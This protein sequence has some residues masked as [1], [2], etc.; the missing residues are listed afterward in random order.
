LDK[1][2]KTWFQGSYLGYQPANLS[3]LET[4]PSPALHNH[5]I[6]LDFSREKRFYTSR[7]HNSII[8][9]HDNNSIKLMDFNNITLLDF[10]WNKLASDN[11]FVLL[12]YDFF[13]RNNDN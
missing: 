9:I 6:Y 7:T 10:I 3:Q 1:A 5:T 11:G 13:F 12:K 8:I 4:G 2:A